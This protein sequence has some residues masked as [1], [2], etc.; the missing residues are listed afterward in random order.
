LPEVLP[1]NIDKVLY[2]DADTLILDGIEELS[3][4]VFE[5][6]I[7]LYAVD[8]KHWKLSGMGD[9]DF[10]G[11]HLQKVG[12]ISDRYFNSGVMLINLKLWRSTNFSNDLFTNLKVH[13]DIIRWWDQDV[14]N[15]S[16][17]SQWNDLDKKF[18]ALNL[19]TRLKD[20]AAIV[21]FTGAS[22]PWHFTNTH[23]YK[24]DYA[25][26]RKMSPFYPYLQKDALHWHSYKF[27]R[28]M[29]FRVIKRSIFGA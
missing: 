6:N 23:P 3:S 7:L 17:G 4:L 25:R 1:R 27:L 28:Y 29:W 2:L 13:K 18:N 15:I 9:I 11:N 8:E 26:Y 14:L 5:K 22:K 16:V 19:K 24:S 20:S 12:L 21:H 10:A